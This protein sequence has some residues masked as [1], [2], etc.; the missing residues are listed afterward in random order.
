MRPNRRG[1]VF[2]VVLSTWTILGGSG[3]G[4]GGGEA[5]QP[6][7]PANAGALAGTW[8][9][10]FVVQPL[11]CTGTMVITD[12]AG[13]GTFDIPGGGQCTPTHGPV[14]ARVADDGTVTIRFTPSDGPGFLMTGR[15]TDADTL[16]GNLSGGMMT[17]SETLSAHRS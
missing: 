10:A 13:V 3:C 2:A 1:L 5:D 9:F 17:G 11:T 4:G 8:T 15:L 12:A 7:G 16:A 6:L 14:S